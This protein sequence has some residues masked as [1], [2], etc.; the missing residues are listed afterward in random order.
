MQNTTGIRRRALA[1]LRIMALAMTIVADASGA[2]EPPLSLADASR[3]T[4]ARHPRLAVF[5][6]RVAALEGERQ[7]AALRPATSVTFDAENLLGSNEL[8]GAQSAELTL[9]LSSV[10]EL[11]GK[12]TAR[13]AVVDARMAQTEAARQAEALDLLGEVT[14][15]YLS[16][17][18]LQE[19]VALSAQAQALA[20]NAYELVS[21]RVASGATPQAEGLRAQADLARAKLQHATMLSELQSS[22]MALASLWGAESIEFDHLEGDLLTFADPGS[23]EELFQRVAESPA[24]RLFSAEQRLRQ[25]AVDL[26]RA[27]S[28]LDIGWSLGVR[29]F[30]ASDD[31]AMVAALSLPLF[32]A[33]RQQGNLQT[34]LAQRSEVEYRKQASLLE[35]RATLYTAWQNYRQN[36][37]TAMQLQRE[38]V[39]LLEQALAATRDAY[40]RGA[41]RYLDWLDARQELIQTHVAIIETASEALLSLAVIE[42]LSG[43]SIAS[44]TGAADTKQSGTTP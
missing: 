10:I 13:L 1:C 14:R 19:K 38:V 24:I 3:L 29:Q 17:Q 40:E 4:I 6:W 22:K 30:A 16:A 9:S 34:A 41:Y 21:R 12:P 39:P 44:A 5:D 32:T 28:R 23:F 11:G 36:S 7:N 26:E 20:E 15:R 35:L 33:S 25:A 42:Q 43:V 2:P 37:S 18:V 27:R 31:T 8:R